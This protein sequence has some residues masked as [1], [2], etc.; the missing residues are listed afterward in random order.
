M[1]DSKLLVSRLV[2]Y[3]MYRIVSDASVTY[4]YGYIS[5][6]NMA[7]SFLMNNQLTCQYHLLSLSLNVVSGNSRYMSMRSYFSWGTAGSRFD[8]PLARSL[9]KLAMV[10]RCQ[11]MYGITSLIAVVLCRSACLYQQVLRFQ[12]ISPPSLR[13]WARRNNYLELEAMNSLSRLMRYCKVIHTIDKFVA[14]LKL[15]HLQWD[16]H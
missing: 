11:I 1:S 15:A 3:K 9:L 6:A 7:A 14:S 8:V 10:L 16:S 2:R 4:M 13:R 5:I 12:N